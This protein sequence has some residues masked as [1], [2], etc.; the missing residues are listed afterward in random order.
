VRVQM[1]RNPTHARRIKMVIQYD[2]TR[3]AGFQR[4]SDF[5]TIQEV[6]ESCLAALLGHNVNVRASGR[7]DAGVHARGQ[8]VAFSTSS[9]IP[10]DRIP[11]AL[12]S[13][14]PDDIIV[15]S[16]ETAVPEFDP[17]RDAVSKTYC[18]RIWRDKYMSVFAHRYVLWYPGRLDF[19]LMLEEAK[20]FVG[21][22]DFL[23]F[24][25]RGSSA[26]TTVRNVSEAK[27]VRRDVYEKE[28]VLWEFWVTADGFLYRMVRRMVGTLIDVGRGHLPKGTVKEALNITDGD[29]SV[30]VGECVP[31]KGLCLEKMQFS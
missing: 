20:E 22:N 13:L 16:A 8:V 7:T 1:K 21:C 31:G 23:N 24:R 4:Q 26:K 6:L 28:D 29:R 15:N 25:N 9:S 12:N 30:K 2:G 27:W 3:Y 19:E 14:L 5:L 10:T 18:Y 17:M 11:K